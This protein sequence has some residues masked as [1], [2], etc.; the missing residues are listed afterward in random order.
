[1]KDFDLFHAQEIKQP[2]LSPPPAEFVPDILRGGAEYT[3]P[4]ADIDPE[5]TELWLTLFTLADRAD[6]ELYAV[7]R[8]L[9]GAGVK[10]APSGKFGYS[11]QPVIDREGK[12]GW[13]SR[14]MYDREKRY[15]NPYRKI[16]ME[17][18]LNLRRL[19]PA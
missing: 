9:R 6:R 18:L 12:K 11:M 15:L 5:G 19:N 4:G 8:Y 10:L 3:D 13:E 1:M 2:S 17:A 16:I 7:L 14:E